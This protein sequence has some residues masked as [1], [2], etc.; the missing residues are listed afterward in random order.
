MY[1]LVTGGTGFIGKRLV[2]K[3]VEEGRKVRCLVRD[4]SNVEELS[5]P[6]VDFF[7]GDIRDLHSI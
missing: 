1:T 5:Y 6:S 4:I 2:K 7:I 3:L